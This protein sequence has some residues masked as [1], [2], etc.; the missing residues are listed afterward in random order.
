MPPIPLKVT[1]GSLFLWSP[2][3]VDFTLR[4]SKFSAKIN[5]SDIGSFS[6]PNFLAPGSSVALHGSLAGDQT[7]GS[8]IVDYNTGVNLHLYFSGSLNFTASPFTVPT[9]TPTKPAVKTVNFTFSGTLNGHLTN[10]FIDIAPT[11]FEYELTGKG[12]VTTRMTK[13]IGGASRDVTSY[14]YSFT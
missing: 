11:V 3:G 9:S 14:F 7:L 6:M 5:L 1:G 10:P 13:I 2:S 12:K 8:G 4:T